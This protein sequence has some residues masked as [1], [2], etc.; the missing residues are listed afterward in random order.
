MFKTSLTALIV[1]ITAS[2]DL[3]LS[4]EKK[5]LQ[6]ESNGTP[7]GGLVDQPGVYD[8]QG[9]FGHPPSG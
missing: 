1:G 3:F 7:G 2:Q 4:E 5:Y 9:E 8:A 6:R